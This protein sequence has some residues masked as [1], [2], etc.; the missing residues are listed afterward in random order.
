[1]RLCFRDSTEE[2]EGCTRHTIDWA[3]KWV[4][5]IY[6]G[7]IQVT[8]GDYFDSSDKCDKL[9]RETPKNDPKTYVRPKS[10]FKPMIDLMESFPDLDSK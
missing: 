3:E 2:T 10:F 6:G 4:L 7:A 1:L 9:I 5:D 8:C